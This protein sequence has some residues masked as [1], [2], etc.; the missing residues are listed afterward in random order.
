GYNT[1]DNPAFNHTYADLNGHTTI[2][3][4]GATLAARK[5]ILV[6]IA[7][8]NE[9]T[10]SW[11]YINT[12]A[13]ADS[14]LAVG[15]VGTNG[16]VASFSGFGPSSDGRIK[17]DVA[18]IGQGTVIETPSNT[19]STGNGTSFA[20]PNMAGLATCLWQGFQEFNNIAIVHALQQAG[21]IAGNPDN[22]TGYG[23]PDVKKAVLI[24]LKSYATSSVTVNNCMPGLTWKSK[25][26]SSM[27]Y[28]IE[29]KLP[30]ENTYS[31]IAEVPGTGTAF[32]SHI[33]QYT[34]TPLIAN[35][36]AIFYRISEVIDTSATGLS[37]DVITSTTVN[38]ASSCITTGI[39][40]VNNSNVILVSPNP[41]NEKIDIKFLNENVI[42]NLIVRITNSIGQ[43]V[44]TINTSKPQGLF[45]IP[46]FISNFPSGKYF[47]SIYNNTNLLITK[48]FIKL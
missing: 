40:N 39:G 7:A 25:D 18:S 31:K 19:V 17:P 29:R 24:L 37:F 34:D 2:S 5:G 8:G 38:L 44:K 28:I 46:V 48:P 3:A 4:I 15:A 21:N 47:I 20:C 11:H 6:L 35:A 27:K 36:G 41:A 16:A 45:Y 12:P 43:T 33:Y 23:I 22:R 42:N 32:N 13:D 26:L 10:T 30:G 1:F 14:I 9:G